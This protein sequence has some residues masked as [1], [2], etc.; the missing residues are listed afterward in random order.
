MLTKGNNAQEM[1]FELLILKNVI[2][3][4]HCE[5]NVSIELTKSKYKLMKIRLFR[6]CI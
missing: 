1:P 4:S 6:L 5:G 2:V 3:I